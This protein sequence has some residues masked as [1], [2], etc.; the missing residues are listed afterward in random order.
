MNGQLQKGARQ[1][2]LDADLFKKFAFT[3]RGDLCPMQAVI[4]GIVAQEVMKVCTYT[5]LL[6]RSV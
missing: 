1:E 4:G 3:A 6:I 5:M 2:K